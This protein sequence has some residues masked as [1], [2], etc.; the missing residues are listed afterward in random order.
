MPLEASR[1][2]H[3]AGRMMRFHIRALD[4]KYDDARADSRWSIM[5]N[6]AHNYR[7][8][9]I[10]HD[11][12]CRLAKPVAGGFTIIYFSALPR[13][14]TSHDDARARV[15][16]YRRR[17]FWQ[18]THGLRDSSAR[19]DFLFLRRLYRLDAEALARL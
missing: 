16:R 18:R 4:F 8:R 2:Q 19:C 10:R 5:P 1:R 14:D 12:H 9:D 7:R 13:M 17:V 3:G 11:D 15:S 6:V